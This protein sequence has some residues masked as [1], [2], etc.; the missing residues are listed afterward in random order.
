MKLLTRWGWELGKEFLPGEVFCSL[1]HL[2]LP[3]FFNNYVLFIHTGLILSIIIKLLL[4][5][6]YFEM[7]R[8]YNMQFHW[9]STVS[10]LF[11]AWLIDSY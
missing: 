5:N 7:E 3:V 9:M 2:F 8:Q 4:S 11:E 6:I 10:V 1:Q